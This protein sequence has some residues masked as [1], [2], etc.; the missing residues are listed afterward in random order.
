[1]QNYLVRREN[2]TLLCCALVLF[3]LYFPGAYMHEFILR[4]TAVRYAPMADA[5]AAGNWEYAF[6]PRVNC[7]HPLISGIITRITG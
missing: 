1:M 3:L 6:H 2:L 7:L 4:D 5:F